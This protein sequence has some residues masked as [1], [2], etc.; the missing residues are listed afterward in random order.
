[1][2]WCSN[3]KNRFFYQFKHLIKNHRSKTSVVFFDQIFATS[4]PYFRLFC[5]TDRSRPVPTF[6]HYE[7]LILMEKSKLPLRKERG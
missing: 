1:M 4:L 7:K 2:R 3:L 6:L 5:N